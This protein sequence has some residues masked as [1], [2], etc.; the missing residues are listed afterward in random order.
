MLKRSIKIFEGDATRQDKLTNKE[1]E[2]NNLYRQIRK[3]K[4]E[5]D[6]SA[7]RLTRLD[8]SIKKPW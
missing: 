8:L 7:D 3:L 4:V 2:I 5:E 1:A 6:F